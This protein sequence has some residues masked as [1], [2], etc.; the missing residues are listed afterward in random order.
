VS[1]LEA[2]PHLRGTVLERAE[3]VEAA[4]A[5]LT[6]SG[7]GERAEAVRGD[8]FVSVPEGTDLLLLSDILHN[9][10]D[11]KV[12][13]LLQNCAKSLPLDGALVV[14]ETMLD[15]EPGQPLNTTMDLS[16][17]TFLGGR[18][19]TQANIAELA[20]RAGLVLAGKKHL[21][22]WRNLLEFRHA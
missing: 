2:H 17:W 14:V 20:E 18:E 15:G 22:T 11:D 4:A 16:M 21:G 8:F 1:L 7:L 9:W 5:R 12:V 19:R 13:I 3:T 6:A 10:P